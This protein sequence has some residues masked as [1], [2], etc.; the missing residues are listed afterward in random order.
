M[1]EAAGNEE[2]RN[3]REQKKKFNIKMIHIKTKLIITDSEAII[4]KLSGRIAYA[5]DSEH[6]CA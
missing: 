1:N 2:A 3:T 4:S 6:F 5:S